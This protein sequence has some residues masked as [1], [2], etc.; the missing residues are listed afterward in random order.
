MK[1]SKRTKSNDPAKILKM[2]SRDEQFERNGGGQWVAM[3]RVFKDKS[4]YDRKCD[5]PIDLDEE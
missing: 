4:K 1:K 5:K 2:I 3:N